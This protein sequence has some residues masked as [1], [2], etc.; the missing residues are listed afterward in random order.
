MT[1]PRSLLL[2]LALAACNSSPIGR[3]PEFTPPDSP[4]AAEEEAAM[5]D[6]LPLPP[7]MA[8]IPPPPR[9]ASS[10][11]LWTGERGSLLGDNRA[12]AR[13]DILTVVIEIDDSAEI[14]NSTDRGRQGSESLGID[15]L[16]GL[17]EALEGG[18]SGDATLSPAVEFSSD[19]SFSG[20]GSVSRNEQLELRVAAAVTEVLPNG[21]LAIAGSQEV[22]VNNELRE[23]LVTGYVR[24]A[25]IS[26]QNEV[27]Y[28]K[29]AQ[30][31]ISYGG[32]GQITDMQQ[33]RVGQQ[34]VD[35][36]LPF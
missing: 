14:S 20:Q 9:A 4:L 2:T 13:G 25:D 28:D 11:S 33:P 24:P 10:A 21:I 7:A 36:L 8:P 30:A 18:L 35:N 19:H 6:P 32:R 26:R 16:F 27:T 1:L 23:L 15:A 12:M 5:R 31:R 22:R 3:P 34:A 17:P 29:I